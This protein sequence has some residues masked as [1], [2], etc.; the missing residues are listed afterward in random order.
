VVILICAPFVFGYGTDDLP[1]LWPQVF[2]T[3][4][5]A[6]VAGLVRLVWAHRV[7]QIIRAVWSGER[8]YRWS[9]AMSVV[10]VLALGVLIP[11]PP[12]S[13]ERLVWAGAVVV[14]AA[15]AGVGWAG[16]RGWLPLTRR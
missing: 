13:A 3:A 8:V 12:G 16:L 5:F 9:T 11:V 14:M 1:V 2:S 4:L 6:V 15:S 7:R 10:T